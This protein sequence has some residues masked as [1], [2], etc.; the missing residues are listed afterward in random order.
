MDSSNIKKSL[1]VI[2]ITLLVVCF[3][4]FFNPALVIY[5]KPFIIPTFIIYVLNNNFNKLTLS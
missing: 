5:I 1:L 2:P 4:D 3:P